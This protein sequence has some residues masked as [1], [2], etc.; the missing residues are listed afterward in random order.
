[1]ISARISP[2][3]KTIG[4]TEARNMMETFRSHSNSDKMTRATMAVFGYYSK[5]FAHVFREENLACMEY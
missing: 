3:D 2:N 5:F 4:I 1:M